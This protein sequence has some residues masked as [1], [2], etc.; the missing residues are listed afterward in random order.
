[1][2]TIETFSHVR[3]DIAE[4]KWRDKF[5]ISFPTD[6]PDLT[7]CSMDSFTARRVHL[8]GRDRRLIMLQSSTGPREFN[9]FATRIRCFDLLLRET[10]Q[11]GS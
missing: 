4:V 8:L 2:F 6:T 10:G 1:M 9:N 3:R 7:A 5:N 11:G